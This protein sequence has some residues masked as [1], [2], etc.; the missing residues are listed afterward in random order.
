MQ[1]AIVRCAGETENTASRRALA[2]QENAP[3]YSKHRTTSIV[4]YRRI[5]A[6][7]SS[8]FVTFFLTHRT[9]PE[10]VETQAVLCLLLG[11]KKIVLVF[12]CGFHIARSS[13]PGFWLVV[14]K[15]AVFTMLDFWSTGS[16]WLVPSALYTIWSAQQ[17]R[18]VQS[19]DVVASLGA[20][21]TVMSTFAQ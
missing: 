9:D 16:A 5:Q 18:P 21:T 2:F 3:R 4:C 19:S 12:L 8:F 1:V 11:G 7:N 13:P 15:A 20:P 17:S 6:F 14:T 10:C